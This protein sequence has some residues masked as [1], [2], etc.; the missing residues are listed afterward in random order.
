MPVDETRFLFF[1]KYRNVIQY[2]IGSGHSYF[3]VM[4]ASSACLTSEPGFIN[5]D[6]N[7]K[8]SL[9]N[10]SEKKTHFF[11]FFWKA[12]L[13][14]VFN[15]CIN[16]N[17]MGEK[18]LTIKPNL[19]LSKLYFSYLE[20]YMKSYSP[21]PPRPVGPISCINWLWLI[22]PSRFWRPPSPPSADSSWPLPPPLP[23]AP[24]IGGLF[25]YSFTL[26]QNSSSLSVLGS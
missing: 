3:R 23:D 24:G 18:K 14:L 7:H 1:G 10:V 26:R 17:L 25:R 9:D 16:F 8:V 22:F 2:D 5:P 6:S 4:H 11:F 13:I 19:V 20:E 21:S 15:I 12:K